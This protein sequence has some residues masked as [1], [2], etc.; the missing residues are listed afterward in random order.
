MT[1]A[2]TLRNIKSAYLYC[3]V[4]LVV[5]DDMAQHAAAEQL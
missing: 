2:K 3:W 4:P 5:F 1:C